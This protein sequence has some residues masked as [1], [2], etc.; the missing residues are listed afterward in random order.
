M[1]LALVIYIIVPYFWVID[2][3]IVALLLKPLVSNKLCPDF[4]LL[5]SPWSYCFSIDINLLTTLFK[6]ML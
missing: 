1:I 5:V 3:Q 6:K 4:K 2:L